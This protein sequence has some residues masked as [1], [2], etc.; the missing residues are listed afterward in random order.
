LFFSV[1]LQSESDFKV[2]KML[3]YLVRTL[4]HLS[5]NIRNSINLNKVVI[6][7]FTRKFF[8]IVLSKGNSLICK[9][10]ISNYKSEFEVDVWDKLWDT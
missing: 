2:W 1:P 6:F 10:I 3:H 4:P 5:A 9:F 8:N 7:N